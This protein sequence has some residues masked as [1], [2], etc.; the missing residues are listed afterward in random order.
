MNMNTARA[1]IA[2]LGPLLIG[3][4]MALA[5]SEPIVSLE[6]ES[7]TVP[8]TNGIVMVRI[9][10]GTFTMGSPEDELGR[11]PDETQREVT[12]SR[13]FYMARTLITQDQY[14]PIA[15]PDF[16]PIYIGAAAY[17]HSNPEPHQGGPWTM[18]SRYR[19]DT[20]KFP[21]DG[22]RWE[23]AVEFCE[24]LTERERDAGRLPGGYVYRLPTEAEWEYACRAGTTGPFN[25]EAPLEEVYALVDGEVRT[26]NAWGL[27]DMHGI[28][29]EWCLDWYGPYAE[30]PATDP[31]GPATGTRRVARGGSNSDG[32]GEGDEDPANRLRFVR[33]AARNHFIPDFPLPLLGLRIVLAPEIDVPDA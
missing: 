10:P 15:V 29:Y 31:V 26:P 4:T 9:E 27:F 20:T 6:A 5:A 18:P 21:M 24:I 12:L 8:D 13:P 14:M 33:S 19:P 25:V 28:K 11:G 17:G 2:G 1:W 30:G 3:A 7:F 23:A 32:H 16:D 22:V